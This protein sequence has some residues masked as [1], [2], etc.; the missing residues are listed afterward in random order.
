[1]SFLQSN[2]I[3]LIGSFDLE[4][5]WATVPIR[6]SS[7]LWENSL[8][9]EIYATE[10]YLDLCNELDRKVTFFVVG[11]F[12]KIAPR[13]IK[14]I[15][16]N[17][18][19][20]ASHSLTHPDMALLSDEEFIR[21]ATLSKEI[22]EQISG[23]EVSGFRAP[24]FSINVRQIQMLSEIGYRYDSSTS[25]ARRLYGGDAKAARVLDPSFKL[26]S[27]MGMNCGG[28]ELTVLGG[29]YLRITPFQFLKKLRKEKLGNM[30]YVHPHDFYRV[31]ENYGHFTKREQ[32]L[33]RINIGQMSQKIRYL[34]E[35]FQIMSALEAIT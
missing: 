33:R 25:T 7:L 5:E 17:G 2:K 9:R 35:T 28:K 30:Y 13:L 22:L 6:Y 4:P 8:A 32:I 23:K 31:P 27:F 19:E 11:M 10:T 16:D 26:L 18:H 1:M 12:A 24:S 14:K 15:A 29:G 34:H 21:E 3:P 20:I